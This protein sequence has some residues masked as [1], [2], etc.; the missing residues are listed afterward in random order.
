MK[1]K[2]TRKLKKVYRNTKHKTK[3]NTRHI[4]HKRKVYKKR[5]YK[6]FIK[7]TDLDIKL[8]ESKI[9]QNQNIKPIPGLKNMLEN[10]N[11]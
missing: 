4:R 2:K 5:S 8:D 10:I 1:H 6:N 9:I 7:N 11:T 3:K